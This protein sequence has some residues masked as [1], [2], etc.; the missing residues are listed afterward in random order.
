MLTRPRVSSAA[1]ASANWRAEGLPSEL[2]DDVEVV[3]RTT[4]GDPVVLA[5]F[6]PDAD[7]YR[8]LQTNPSA[9]IDLGRRHIRVTARTLDEH[10]AADILASYERRN[11]LAAPVIH[12]VLSALV[13]W[14]YDGSDGARDR[15]VQQLPVV[16]FTPAG[17]VDSPLSR[18][19]R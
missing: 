10:Q 14:P 4:A 6:G 15:L 5:G 1:A 9:E 18:E 8:N 7:W 19:D 16:A 13:E 2:L 11:R 17:L 3:G 12:R